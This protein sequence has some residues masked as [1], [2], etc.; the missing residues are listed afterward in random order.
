ME[1]NIVLIE[2]TEF[3]LTEWVCPLRVCV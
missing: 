1:K 2:H 3:I